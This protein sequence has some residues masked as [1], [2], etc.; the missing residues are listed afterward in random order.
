MTFGFLLFVLSI[1]LAIGST[2]L[3]DRYVD[4]IELADIRKSRKLILVILLDCYFYE[5]SVLLINHL[6]YFATGVPVQLQEK[7]EIIIVVCQMFYI[8]E[9]KVENQ[10]FLIGINFQIMVLTNVD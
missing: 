7:L 8:L 2:A 10:L 3:A 1:A 9:T 6:A 5:T 4:G